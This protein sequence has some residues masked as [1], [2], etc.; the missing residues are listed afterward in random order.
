MGSYGDDVRYCRHIEEAKLLQSEGVGNKNTKNFRLA[1]A[2]ARRKRLDFRRG[3]LE[4]S[5]P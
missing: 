2:V 1:E 3:N 4:D 5:S